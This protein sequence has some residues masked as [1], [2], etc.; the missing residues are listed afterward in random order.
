MR[1]YSRRTILF[2]S[3]LAVASSQ[4]PGQARYD[5]LVRGG[6]V[7]DPSQNLSALRDIAIARGKVARIAESI[8]EAEA[9]QVVDARGKIVKPG[10]IDIHVHVY[11]GV[12]PLGI[13]V[14]PL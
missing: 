9:R 6:H 1:T 14:V 2:Q 3:T 5:L 7:V 11:D 12:A 10:L 13:P 8:P 4:N